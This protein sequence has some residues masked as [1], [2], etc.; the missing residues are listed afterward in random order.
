MVSPIYRRRPRHHALYSSAAISA[1]ECY[2]LTTALKGINMNPIQAF[3]LFELF[4]KFEAVA[5]GKGN[6]MTKFLMYVHLLGTLAATL[7]VPTLAQNW[8]NQPGHATYFVIGVGLSVLLHTLLPSIFAAP[9][10]AA[11]KQAGIG[12]GAGMVL[13]M[14]GLSMALAQPVKAQAT[15]TTPAPAAS[16]PVFTGSTDAIGMRWKGAWGTGNLTTESL[17]FL[18]FGKTKSQHVFVEGHELISSA[19]GFNAYTGG[20]AITPDLTKLLAKTNVT[21]ANLSVTFSASVGSGVP[22]AG[23][24][25]IAFLLG[26]GVKYKATSALSWNPLQVQWLRYGSNNAPVISGGLSYIFK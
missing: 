3:R 16:S 11:Q 1:A 21:P 12:S 25:H 5:K 26:G 14:L 6:Y 4:K 17:D 19:A 8:L 9:S 10:D 18:D 20:L 22:N 15:T 13:L 24:S 23:N 2:S 7:G